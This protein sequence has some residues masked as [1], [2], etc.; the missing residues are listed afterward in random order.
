[1]NQNFKDVAVDSAGNVYV[2]GS[3][4]G[5]TDFGGGAVLSQGSVDAMLV[6]YS[7]AGNY[8]W[9][10]LFA[11]TGSQNGNNISIDTQGNPVLAGQYQGVVDF[12]LGLQMSAGLSDIFVA[13]YSSNNAVQWVR[14]YGDASSQVGW[15]IDLDTQNN[16]IFAGSMG[17]AIDFGG[18]T[19]TSAGGNDVYAVKL[20][21]TGNYTWSRRAGD[22]LEQ[23]ARAVATDGSN[24]SYVV[25]RF[26]GS[27]DFG[28][29]TV[30]SMGGYDGFIA[31][32]SP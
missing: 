32:Y 7:S 19:L 28:T 1:M 14:G 11:G 3:F 13:K 2:T 4:A 24:N 12:G 31:K 30:T 17:G 8:V 27:V 21:A 16:V 29:G 22:S 9:M 6:K 18:G 26:Q 23:L 5:T 10:R 20:S 25:G 15:G